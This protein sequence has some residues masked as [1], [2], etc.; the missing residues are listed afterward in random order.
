MSAILFASVVSFVS[1]SGAVQDGETK[2]V[3]LNPR[4][5]QPEIR[6]IPMAERQST[7]D[8][9]T[10]YVVDV[11]Y[12]NTRPFVDELLKILQE[13]HPLTTFTFRMKTGMYLEDDPVLWQAIRDDPN[14]AGAIVTI[15]H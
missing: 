6:R 5:I 14:T 9:K 10:V 15:G 4:G 8:G 7:L 13:R 3:V 11:N 1:F 2:I 12:P